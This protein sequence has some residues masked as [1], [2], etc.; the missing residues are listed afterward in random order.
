MRRLTAGTA[1]LLALVGTVTGHGQSSAP[2]WNLVANTIATDLRGAYDLVATDLNKDGKVDL[3]AVATG[4]TDLVWFEN[5]TWTRH[6]IGNE[7][8]AGINAAAFDTDKDGIP[9]VVV[10]SRFSTTPAKS[11]GTLTLFTHGA[12]VNAPWA[13]KDID[14][15]PAAHRLRWIDAEGNGKKLLINAPL[16]GAKGTAPDYKDQAF[17]YAY[18][19]A[20]WKR[21]TVTDAEDGVIHGL[22]VTDWDGKGREAL[23]TSSFLGVHIHRYANGQWTRTRLIAGNGEP[24]PQ[25]GASDVTALK[26]KTGRVFSHACRDGYLHH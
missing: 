12:D 1:A 20:D 8:R 9:E 23:L 6:V 24:W 16:G 15:T 17:V 11:L 19:P 22:Y 26:M 7:V 4:N 3:L 14:A 2:P 5:P 25:S 18:D 13:A 10:A 21:Q